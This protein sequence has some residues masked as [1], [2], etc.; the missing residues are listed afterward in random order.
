MRPILSASS[1]LRC[2]RSLSVSAVT[3]DA[4]RMSPCFRTG[5]GMDRP[6]RDR[7]SVGVRRADQPVAEQTLRLLEPALQIAGGV[8][9]AEIEP[10]RGERLRDLRR[11]AR[12]DRPRAHE[13]RR[14]HG[15][16]EVARDARVD[17]GHPRDVH[18][19]DLRAIEPYRSE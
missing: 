17:R 5:T 4:M 12:D 18:D 14:G 11:E 16:Q 15:L 13:P 19:D 1:S 6:L 8:E 2:N 7:G 10:E 9:F 3:T